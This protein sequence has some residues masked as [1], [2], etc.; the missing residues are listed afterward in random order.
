MPNPVL[1][2]IIPNQWN[3]VATNAT[4]GVIYNISNLEMR[5]TYRMTGDPPPTTLEEGVDIGD[6]YAEISNNA[7]IDIYLWSDTQGKVR[8]DL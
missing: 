8:V 5:Q 1:I 2:T 3:L 6:G 4:S 7:G